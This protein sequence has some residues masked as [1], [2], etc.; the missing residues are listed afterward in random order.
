MIVTGKSLF[1]K[2]DPLPEKQGS[3]SVPRTA[4]NR[5]MYG[6]VW[7]ATVDCDIKKGERVLYRKSAASLYVYEGVEYHAIKESDVLAVVKEK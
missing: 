5:S 4:K 6:T 3:L 2:P 1:I 7:D